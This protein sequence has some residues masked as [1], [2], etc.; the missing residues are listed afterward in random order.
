M[1]CEQNSTIVNENSDVFHANQVKSAALV[2][3][4]AMLVLL[5]GSVDWAVVDALAHVVVACNGVKP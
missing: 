1:N 3:L 2:R 4:H 5:P